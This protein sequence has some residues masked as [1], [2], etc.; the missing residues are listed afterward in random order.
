MFAWFKKHK[1]ARRLSKL[2]WKRGIYQH[3]QNRLIQVV[4][5]MEAENDFRGARK[6]KAALL[7]TV[8]ACNTNL[9]GSKHES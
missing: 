2:A 5:I 1:E 8:V 4:K 9:K 3:A 6:M 7:T